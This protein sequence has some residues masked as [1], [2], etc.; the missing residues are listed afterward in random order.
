MFAFT[1]GPYSPLVCIASGSRLSS[2]GKK[3]K[4]MIMRRRLPR[5]RGARRDPECCRDIQPR[6]QCGD[7]FAIELWVRTKEES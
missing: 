2:L 3:K 7:H 1:A 5:I 6:T 4:K